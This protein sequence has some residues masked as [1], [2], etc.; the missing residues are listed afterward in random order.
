ME[1][2]IGFHPEVPSRVINLSESMAVEQQVPNSNTHGT[3][4]AA[5]P[6]WT[7]ST[8]AS[9]S[10]HSSLDFFRPNAKDYE[11]YFLKIRRCIK[12]KVELDNTSLQLRDKVLETHNLFN[13]KQQEEYGR[14]PLQMPET[15]PSKA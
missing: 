14:R 1:W 9:H 2:D 4:V 6:Q 12:T 15:S 7:T 10:P 13:H 8:A 3:G 11:E 5:I